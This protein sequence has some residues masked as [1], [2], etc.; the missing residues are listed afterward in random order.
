M[1]DA[2]NVSTGKPKIGGAIYRAPV[3]TELPTDTATPLD[4]AFKG[5]GY[6]SEDGLTNSNSP[7][8]DNTKAWGGDTVLTM[9]K[10]KE[11]EFK[12]TLIESLNIDV[13]KTVYGDDNVTGTLETGIVIKANNNEMDDSAWVI[14][15]ILKAGVLK[16]IVIPNG[17]VSEIG[18]I[19]YADAD[20]VGYETTLEA[21]PDTDE[22]THYEYIQKPATGTGV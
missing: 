20:A 3:G 13:L 6:I 7:E 15:M 11:D 2:K 12:F 21:M 16:R 9:Q 5:L 22:N 4:A 10:S 17:K 19:S 1:A 18:E 8:S 14:D